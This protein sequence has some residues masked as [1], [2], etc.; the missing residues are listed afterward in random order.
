VEN[1]CPSLSLN[2]ASR[3]HGQLVKRI[4]DTPPWLL[5]TAAAGI[6]IMGSLGSW[7]TGDNLL[8]FLTGVSCGLTSLCA[9]IVRRTDVDPAAGRSEIR[10]LERVF[11]VFAIGASLSIGLMAARVFLFTDDALAHL[12]LAALTL[13]AMTTVL[14]NYFRPRLSIGQ[15][16]ALLAPAA[17]ALLARNEIVYSILALGTAVCGLTVSQIVHRLYEETRD[18]LLKD[19]YLKRQNVQFDAALNNMAQGLCM[20]DAENRLLVCNS[21]YLKMYAFSPK[22]VRPGISLHALLQHSIDVK[23][24]HGVSADALYA[25]IASHIDAKVA[26]SFHHRMEDGRTILVAFEPMSGGG[27]VTTHEDITDRLAAA[28]Q[29]EYLA[30]HDQLTGLANRTLF[31]KQLQSELAKAPTGLAVMCIDLDYFKP[32]NDTFGHVAGDALLKAVSGRLKGSVR[33]CDLVARLGGDEFAIISPEASAELIESV[34]E[35]LLAVLNGPYKIMGNS[36]T[37]SASIGIAMSSSDSSAP[38]ELLRN[39]DIALYKAKSAGRGQFRFAS[40]KLEDSGRLYPQEQ[41][42]VLEQAETD[43]ARYFEEKNR[44]AA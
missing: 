17:L 6:A 29:I 19:E 26:S 30:T 8:L 31:Q 18:S 7:R 10:R 41:G 37:I 42:A 43:P 14:R 25:N 24:H 40:D 21:R 1:A 4:Y 36:I 27:W 2:S 3:V 34:S 39:A 44:R 11:A 12:M 35:R 38:D 32:V 33:D 5:L 22:V 20:F 16:L 15:L 23:N 9:L 13:T 28:A